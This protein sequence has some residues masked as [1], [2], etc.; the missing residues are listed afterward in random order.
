MFCGCKS[1]K[2]LNISEFDVDNAMS[3]RCMFFGCNKEF[4]NKIRK[5]FKN[6]KEEA[7]QGHMNGVIFY[8]S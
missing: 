4:Q 5:Q 6:I 1:L 3:M 8:E 2:E 7:F